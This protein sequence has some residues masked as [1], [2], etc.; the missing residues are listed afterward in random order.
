MGDT[1]ILTQLLA[2]GSATNT[3]DE[4]LLEN[5]NRDLNIFPMPKLFLSWKGFDAYRLDDMI[6][7]FR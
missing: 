4:T 6:D 1:A 5:L 7:F 3:S 2:G